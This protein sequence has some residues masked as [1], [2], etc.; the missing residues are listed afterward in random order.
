VT[1]AVSLTNR[2][3]KDTVGRWYSSARSAIYFA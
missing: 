2:L 1:I 3:P